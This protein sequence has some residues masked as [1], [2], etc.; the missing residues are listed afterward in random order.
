MDFARTINGIL[1]IAKNIDYVNA[2]I[3]EEAAIFLVTSDIL[4]R[5]SCITWRRSKEYTILF[6]TLHMEMKF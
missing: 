3:K 1:Y 4:Y 2:N 6:Y 5:H